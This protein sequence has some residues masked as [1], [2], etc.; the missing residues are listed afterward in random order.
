MKRSIEQKKKVV[1][2]EPYKRIFRHITKEI[3]KISEVKPKIG[4]ISSNPELCLKLD[5]NQKLK[6]QFKLILYRNK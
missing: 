3:T 6:S 5:P 2:L 1:V 4:V